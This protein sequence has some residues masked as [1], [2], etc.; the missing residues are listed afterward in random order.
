MEKEKKKK[1]VEKEKAVKPLGRVEVLE[2]RI[3]PIG[4]PWGSQQ[5]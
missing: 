3:T 2:E 5:A 1:E 4:R